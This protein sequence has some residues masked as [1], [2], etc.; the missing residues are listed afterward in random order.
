[1]TNLETPTQH[2]SWK[3]PIFDKDTTGGS[4]KSKY[5]MGAR[6]WCSVKW[7]SSTGDLVFDIRVE[8]KRGWGET[9]G[10]VRC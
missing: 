3:I 7:S 2:S 4:P 10:C 5:V 9:V 1:M 8:K 6:N